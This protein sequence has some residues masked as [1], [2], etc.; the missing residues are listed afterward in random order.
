MEHT[1]AYALQFPPN[2]GQRSGDFVRCW[3]KESRHAIFGTDMA[4]S[5][6]GS[7]DEAVALQYEW[8]RT[9]VVA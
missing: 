8:F 5:W 6:R 2:S 1:Y 4:V 3:Y 9:G 7:Y